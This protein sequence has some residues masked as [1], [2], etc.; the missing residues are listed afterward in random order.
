MKAKRAR[1]TSA[2]DN[3][4]DR[5]LARVGHSSRDRWTWFL[6]VV[7][8]YRRDQGSSWLAGEW[9][10]LR[11]CLAVFSTG[12]RSL[13]GYGA[14]TTTGGILDEKPSVAEIKEVLVACVKI[15]DCVA[16][17]QPVTLAPIT[18]RPCLRWIDPMKRYVLFEEPDEDATRT[19]SVSYQTKHGSAT[20]EVADESSPWIMRV[21]YPLTKMISA[22][23]ARIHICSSKRPHEG[24]PCGNF[25][26]KAKRGIYCSRTCT[27]R[28]MTR[29]HRDN[30]AKRA[31]K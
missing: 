15:L 2:S 29:R 17:R 9:E 27:S 10:D 31:G 6:D 21:C 3:E 14:I 1:K 11:G 19:R 16:R 20:A 30:A 13:P 22:E 26:R 8:R 24:K 25:F 4:Y 12:E 28:E 5:Y 7:N 23:G 18:I